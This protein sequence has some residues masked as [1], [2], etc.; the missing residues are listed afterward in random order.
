MR[1][2]SEQGRRIEGA[3]SFV[4]LEKGKEEVIGEG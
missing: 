4:F 1:L 2:I 3:T